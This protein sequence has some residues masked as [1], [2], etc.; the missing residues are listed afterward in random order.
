M[1]TFKNTKYF[2]FGGL[3]LLLIIHN[4]AAVPL[5]CY[6]LL[7]IL[8]IS[9]IIYGSY[10]INSNFYTNVTCNAPE[11]KNEIAITFDDGPV[12]LNTPQILD[13]LKQNNIQAAF[14]CIGNKIN[15][16]KQIIERIQ[17]EGHLIGNHSYSHHFF[18]DLFSREMMK[19]EL[20][21]TNAIIEKIIRK[22]IKFFRPPYGVTTPVLTKVTI[23]CGLQPIGWS[24]RS[25]DTVIKDE[26]KLISKIKNN[27][28]GGD[29]L[30]LHDSASVTVNAL[31][32]I[33]NEIKGK[34]L[35]PVRLDHLLKIEAYA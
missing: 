34:G 9:A 26:S 8:S 6:A 24:L 5:W 2:F 25:M 29:V 4:F 30:L 12:T 7:L 35:K 18:F 27:I 10:F 32:S 3:L 14:F 13:I 19:Y 20:E 23:A 28:K 21:Q 11:N 31:Q 33:I 16:N 17:A 1:L 22:R 15:A